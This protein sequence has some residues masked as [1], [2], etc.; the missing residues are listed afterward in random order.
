MSV[1]VGNSGWVSG[2]L[3]VGCFGDVIDSSLVNWFGDF[4]SLVFWKK[5][6]FA[7]DQNDKLLLVMRHGKAKGRDAG[8]SDFDRRLRKRG[9]RDA[10]RMGELL[11][12]KGLV[13]DVIISSSAVRAVMTAE[14]VA[15]SCGYGGEVVRM[16][17]LYLGNAEEYVRVLSEMGYEEEGK[18][19]MERVMVVGHQPGLSLLVYQ[20][21]GQSVDMVTGAIA[22]I[23][24]GIDG[25]DAVDEIG[26]GTG[27]LD[28]VYEPDGGD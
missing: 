22:V 3:V 28:G 20:L 26:V 1:R 10:K 5:W 2:R 19:L 18:G 25:W 4:E 27:K 21:T 7:M 23:R 6:K 17:S 8:G 13:P 9:L 15:D 11:A 24:L 14:A 12:E 16:E